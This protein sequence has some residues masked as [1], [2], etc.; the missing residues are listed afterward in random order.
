MYKFYE[1]DGEFKF[2]GSKRKLFPFDQLEV[3]QS[4]P[5]K[6]EDRRT[7]IMAA[8]YVRKKTG[9]IFSVVTFKDEGIARCGRIK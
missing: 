6:L 2:V 1:V 5:I 8:Q 9:K 4:F 7:C 3:G